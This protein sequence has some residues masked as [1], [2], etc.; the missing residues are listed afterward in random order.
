MPQKSHSPT[1]ST[2]SKH[3]TQNPGTNL[4]DLGGINKLNIN[5]KLMGFHHFE[6][7]I[8]RATHLVNKCHTAFFPP[9]IFSQKLLEIS[10]LETFSKAWDFGQG[11]Y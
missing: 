3:W 8:G 10:I 7:L 1:T 9:Q 6:H 5:W 2:P 11:L 4:K